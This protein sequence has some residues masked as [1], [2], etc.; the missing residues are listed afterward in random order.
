MPSV[1]DT[2]SDAGRH[3][4]T[5]ISQKNLNVELHS[6]IGKFVSRMWKKLKRDVL[7]NITDNDRI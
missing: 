5:I 2:A 7:E 4:R 3:R 6:R 1:L